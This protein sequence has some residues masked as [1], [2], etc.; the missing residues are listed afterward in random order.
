[1]S[2]PLPEAA[3]R[4]TAHRLRTAVAGGTL[5][6]LVILAA[7][8]LIM[9]GQ[10]WASSAAAAAGCV[11]LAA[12]SLGTTTGALTHPDGMVAWVG[13]GYLA[14][15]AVVAATL[16][17]ARAVGLDAAWAG[18]WLIAQIVWCAVAEVTTLVRTPPIDEDTPGAGPGTGPEDGPGGAGASA[19]S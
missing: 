14:K 13:G 8:T 12:C 19:G 16:F 4:R 5:A 1:M 2:R 3:S 11:V 9:P 10:P 6:L 15:I 17:G 18:W 7:A